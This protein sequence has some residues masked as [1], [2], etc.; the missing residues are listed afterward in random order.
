MVD[1]ERDFSGEARML[2]QGLD[3]LTIDIRHLEALEEHYECMF[4][5]IVSEL[6]DLKRR[7]LVHGQ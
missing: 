3:G 6:D 1:P 4:I 5:K 7:I 2:L